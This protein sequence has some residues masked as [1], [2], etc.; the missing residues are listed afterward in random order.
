MG[1]EATVAWCRECG[2]GVRPGSGDPEAVARKIHG[3]GFDSISDIAAT[4]IDGDDLKEMGFVTMYSRKKAERATG[5]LF[6]S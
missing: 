1:F 5:Y 3:Q 2:V 6:P 4:G